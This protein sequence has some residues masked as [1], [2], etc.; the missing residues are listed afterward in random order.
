MPCCSVR[1]GSS[2]GCRSRTNAASRLLLRMCS[3]SRPPGRFQACSF[4]HLRPGWLRCGPPTTA[5]R[6]RWWSGCAGHCIEDQWAK[7]SMPSW[8][9][10]CAP[11]LLR[12]DGSRGRTSTGLAR[13]CYRGQRTGPTFAMSR[14]IG[15]STPKRPG[16]R[17]PIWR[18]FSRLGR[19]RCI[20]ALA[21]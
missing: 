12:C 13:M 20:L 2:S 3:H 21:V 9:R 17:P 14:A 1:W 6:Q 11:L 16:P 8:A 18:P 15:S 7:P 19:S 10:R 4:L 5:C